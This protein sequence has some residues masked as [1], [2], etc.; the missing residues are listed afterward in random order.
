MRNISFAL[1]TRQ[2]RRRKKTV[3]RRLGWRDLEP[4]TLLQPVVKSQG[5]KKGQKVRKIGRP[6]RVVDVR[7]EVLRRVIDVHDYGRREVILEG[8]PRMTPHQF[9][10]FFCVANRCTSRQFVTRIEYEYD[11]RRG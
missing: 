5:L 10:Q 7:R 6:I 2:V 1:T 4:G 9:V 3:T 8:F 11:V